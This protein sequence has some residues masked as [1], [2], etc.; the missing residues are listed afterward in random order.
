MA[1]DLAAPPVPEPPRLVIELLSPLMLGGLALPPGTV[2]HLGGDVARQL[3]H[4]RRARLAAPHH[5]TRRGH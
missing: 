3:L 1:H 4:Q 2:V 5:V